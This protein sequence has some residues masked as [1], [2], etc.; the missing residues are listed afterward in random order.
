MSLAVGDHLRI[1]QLN[2][3]I[4]IQT[5]AILVETIPEFKVIYGKY[6]LESMLPELVKEPLQQWISRGIENSVERVHHTVE[7]Q[8]FRG[9][10]VAERAE[11]QLELPPHVIRRRF[12]T[13]GQHFAYWCVTGKRRYGVVGHI[14]Q[15][16]MQTAMQVFIVIFGG[17][18]L[19]KLVKKY[20]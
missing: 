12:G 14:R 7:E 6:N 18:F 19:Q 2:Q 11:A 16:A 15:D 4:R 10:Q 1:T 17:F 5:D 8:V 13:R 20:L 3:G 9:V